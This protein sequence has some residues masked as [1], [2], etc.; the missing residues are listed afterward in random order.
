MPVSD[1]ELVKAWQQVLTLSQLQAGQTVTVLTSAATHPQ[2]LS[3]ALIAAQ[4]MGAVVNRLDLPPVNG[5][6]ALSR[7]SLA[8]LGTTPLTGNKPAIAALKE[9]DLVL[10]LM[11]LLFSPE[12]HEILATGTKI[13]LAVEPPEVLA[14]LVPTEADRA[15]VKAAAARIGAAREMSVVSAAGT[16]LRCP[17]GEF[18]AISEYGFVDEPGRWDHWPSGFVLT[19]PNERGANGKIVIDVGDILLPQ[20]LYVRS[21]IELTVENGFATRIEGGVDAELLREYVASF[22]D[23]EAYAISHIGWGLQPRAHWTTLGLYDREATIGMDARAYEGNFLFSLG[24][25]NEAGG[26]RSTTCHIDIPLRACTVRLDGEDVVR[27]GK[28]LDGAA[29]QE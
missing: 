24:P 7:D 13:L 5:E 9:S 3:T 18:P 16:D 2:T 8:Y 10:D 27:Q 23:P 15:R 1:Y 12:Q 17:L 14:R 26:S 21:P 4:S 28:V 20:K 22:R 29:R 11:T 6:K 19:W 25:N